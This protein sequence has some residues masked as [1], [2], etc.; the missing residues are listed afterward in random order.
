MFVRQTKKLGFPTSLADTEV[1]FTQIWGECAPLVLRMLSISAFRAIL[2]DNCVTA[3]ALAN[4]MKFH[5]P[6]H[7]L[8]PGKFHEISVT[9]PA[10]QISL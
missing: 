5:R 8:R 1:G 4:F 10:W 3:C 6:R 2:N 7:S 9:F